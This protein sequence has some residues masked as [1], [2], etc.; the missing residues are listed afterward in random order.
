MPTTTTFALPFPSL[1]AV[2][3]IPADVQSLAEKTEA[4][5]LPGAAVNITI[6]SGYEAWSGRTP[7]ARFVGGLIVLAGAIKPTGS[8]TTFPAN[9]GTIVGN[10]P[11][12]YRPLEQVEVQLAGHNAGSTMKGWVTTG[13][14]IV[15]SAGSAPGQY[16][17]LAPFVYPRTA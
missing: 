9:A 3:N 6:S 11:A 13:G 2:P 12:P 7:R 4:S 16:T 5:L 14:D 10:V 17:H 1:S 15:V 8:G